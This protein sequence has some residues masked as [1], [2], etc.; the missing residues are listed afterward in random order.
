M[1]RD[2]CVQRGLCLSQ[3]RFEIA[4]IKLNE[5]IAGLHALIVGDIDFRNVARNF[6]TYLNDVSVN[7]SV[8]SRFVR[9]RI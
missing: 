5:Q 7:E 9:A 6:R 4:R 8:V 2:S 3:F 1:L